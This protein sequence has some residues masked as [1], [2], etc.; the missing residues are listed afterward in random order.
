M[1]PGEAVT[2]H[3]LSGGAWAGLCR[4]PSGHWCEATTLKEE[5]ARDSQEGSARGAL[6]V[7]VR[8]LSRR[9]GVFGS[10]SSEGQ[11]VV[12]GL[13]ENRCAAD[14]PLTGTQAASTLKEL[15]PNSG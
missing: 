15:A 7:W 9:R 12:W 13:L 8:L 11:A 4:R 3:A 10:Q 6:C 5:R 1:G 2:R 14:F